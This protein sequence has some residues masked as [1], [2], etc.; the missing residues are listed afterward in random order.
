MNHQTVK[1]NSVMVDAELPH[2]AYTCVYYSPV[3]FEWAYLACSKQ[4]K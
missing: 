3:H 1:S 2:P 4:G